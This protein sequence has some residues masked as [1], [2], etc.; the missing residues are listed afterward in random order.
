MAKPIKK[1]KRRYGSGFHGKQ[2]A[3]II[4]GVLIFAAIIFGIYWIYQNQGTVTTTVSESNIN[5]GDRIQNFIKDSGL[6]SSWILFV[7]IGGMLIAYIFN[8]K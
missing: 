3:G 6:E 5:I 1:G 8:K 2:I 4:I 7:A